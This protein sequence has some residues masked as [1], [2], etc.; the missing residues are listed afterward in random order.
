MREREEPLTQTMNASAVRDEWSQV[1][2]RVGRMQTRV[3]VEN[4]GIAVAA[5]V[6]AEDL[7]LLKRF[8]AERAER[9]AAL[10]RVGAAFEDV[11]ATELEAEVNKAVMAVRQEN[12]REPAPQR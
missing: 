5:I 3:V 2:D 1:L 8:E 9:F 10:D 4:N 7:A 6:S 12:R 11:P